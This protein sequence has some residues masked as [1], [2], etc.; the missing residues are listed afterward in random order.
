MVSFLGGERRVVFD[1][2]VLSK[3]SGKAFLYKYVHILS[4]KGTAKAFLGDFKGLGRD[5]SPMLF[6]F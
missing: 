1:C 2:L 5:M 4:F 6:T 3:A